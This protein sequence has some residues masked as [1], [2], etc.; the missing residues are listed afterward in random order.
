MVVLVSV[1]LHGASATPLSTWYGRRVARQTLA[2]EREATATGLFQHDA[3]EV[4]RITPAELAVRLATPDPPIVLD[5]RTRS[6]YEQDAPDPGS[7]RVPPDQV[8]A[9]PRRARGA[10][11]R[12]LYLTERGD[13]RPCGATVTGAWIR[14]GGARGRLQR[15]AC[16]VPGRA[17]TF[18]RQ[19]REEAHSGD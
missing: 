3:T 11:G 4:P 18:L 13:Q 17:E 19:A 9:G 2:E 14:R 7:V 15:L 1:V 6:Q 16:S 5:V 12:L 8:E 10:R